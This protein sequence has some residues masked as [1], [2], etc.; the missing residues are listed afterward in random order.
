[1]IEPIATCPYWKNVLLWVPEYGVFAASWWRGRRKGGDSRD[2]GYADGF[3]LITP[4]RHGNQQVWCPIPTQFRQVGDP[5]LPTYWTE[6]PPD[7]PNPNTEG[8]REHE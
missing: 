3:D 5:P 8:S 4:Y 1:M 6:L 2:M 7:P